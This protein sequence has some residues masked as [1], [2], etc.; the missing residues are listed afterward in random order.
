MGKL[1]IYV[2]RLRIYTILSN[3]IKQIFP[4]IMIAPHG[5]SMY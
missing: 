3:K 1:L 5:T 2:G 4:N